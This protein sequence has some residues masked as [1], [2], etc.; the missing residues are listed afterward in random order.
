MI[1]ERFFPDASPRAW[2]RVSPALVLALVR[3]RYTTHLRELDGL[4]LAAALESTGKYV[5]LTAGVR[6]RLEVGA[7]QAPPAAAAPV[8]TKEEQQRLLLQRQHRFRAT[9][10]G[11]DPAYPGNRQ[12]ADL[13]LRQLACKALQAAAWDVGEAAVILAGGEDSDL[14]SRARAR[15]ETFLSN[16]ERRLGGPSPEQA[17]R[18]LVEEWRGSLD[19]LTPLLDALQNGWIRGRSAEAGER[20]DEP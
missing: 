9:E 5:D 7:G 3:H 11:R 13:H 19:A 14:C 4:L 2:P 1:A 10:C 16:I 15:S 18:A 12:T 6:R 17:R 20:P 8:F